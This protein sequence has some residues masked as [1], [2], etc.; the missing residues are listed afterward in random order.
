MIE[1]AEGPIVAT[2]A[3]VGVGINSL[4]NRCNVLF[5]EMD[6]YPVTVL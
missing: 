1:E 2:M 3:S 5:A 6:F 4:K